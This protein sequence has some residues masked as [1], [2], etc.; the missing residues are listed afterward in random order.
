M[1]RHYAMSCGAMELRLH[2]PWG[3]NLCYH[4][5]VSW[6]G[7]HSQCGCIVGEEETSCRRLNSRHAAPIH[8]S[9]WANLPLTN[10]S[11]CALS[12]TRFYISD[13]FKFLI[14]S[15]TCKH[16]NMFFLKPR[17]CYDWILSWQIKGCGSTFYTKYPLQLIQC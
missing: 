11:G 15:V 14:S 7:P 4:F 13:F 5:R 17:S 3:R 9:Q 6:T 1:L 10:W 16:K 12:S 8:F 2:Y